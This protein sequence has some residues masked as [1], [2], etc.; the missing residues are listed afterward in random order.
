MPV[1]GRALLRACGIAATVAFFGYGCGGLNVAIMPGAAPNGNAKRDAAA[2]PAGNL[3]PAGLSGE[4][5]PGPSTASA[6]EVTES[7]S[8]YS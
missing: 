6:G 7:T 2:R 8:T 1:S 5:L 3:G 4:N